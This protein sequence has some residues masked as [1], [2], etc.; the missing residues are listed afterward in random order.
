[1]LASA[2]VSLAPQPYADPPPSAAVGRS[3]SPQPLSPLPAPSATA[4]VGINFRVGRQGTL[5]VDSFV[6]GGP[7]ERKGTLAPGDTLVSVDGKDVSTLPIDKIQRL[8]AGPE[9][10]AVF[11]GFSRPGEKLD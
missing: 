9:G 3:R 5:C 4:G 1:M 8:V 7:E 10:E 2:A 11:L 6:P